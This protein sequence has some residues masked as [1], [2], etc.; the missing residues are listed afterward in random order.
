MSRKTLI[1]PEYLLPVRPCGCVL[2][3]H[4]VLIENGQVAAIL[5]REEAGKSHQDADHVELASHVLMPGL[6]N[7][8]THSPMTLLRGYADD[9]ELYEWLNN[10]IWPVEKRNVSPQFVAEGTRLAMAEMIRAGTTCFNDNYFYPN[11]MARVAIEAGMRA[12]IGLPLLDQATRWAE[13][14]EEYMSK[15]LAVVDE[16]GQAPLIEFTL[17]P[18][19]PYSVSDLGMRRI[20][21]VSAQSGLKVHLHCLETAYDIQHSLDTHGNHPLDRLEQLGLLNESLI[22]VHMTQLDEGDVARLADCGTHVVHCPQSNLKLASGLCPVSRL[23]DAGVNV[24]VGTDGAASNNNLDMLEEGRVAALLAKGVSGDATALDAITA[25]DMMT[26]NG[27]KALG[28][29]ELIGSIEPGKRADLCALDLRAPQTQPVHNLFSQITYAASSAQFTDV[30]IDGR[31][32]METG[33]LTSLDEDASL[34]AAE[35]WQMKLQ[36]DCSR[37]GMGG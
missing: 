15:G 32:V 4:A 2:K 34:A 29:E 16:Y 26:I 37:Q 5:P 33:R 13:D 23:L 8:H 21:E 9:L 25:V 14:F 18:H 1:L 30:W 6:I 11:E 28:L 10:H 22:A 35:S 17:A 20:A 19:A 31:R 36:S 12:V 7:M 24:S 3:N 27:A